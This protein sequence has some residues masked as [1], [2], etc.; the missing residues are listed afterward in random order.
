VP[1]EYV[2]LNLATRVADALALTSVLRHAFVLGN[3]ATDVNNSLGWPR[4]STHFWYRSDGENVSGAP[5]LLAR[6]PQLSA[7]SLTGPERAFVAGYLSHLISDEQEILTL[8]PY[9]AGLS[10]DGTAPDRRQVRLASL[11]AVDAAVEADDPRPMRRSVADLRAAMELQLRD[12]LLPFVA[13]TAVREWAA[14]TLAVA[15][16]PASWARI[17]PHRVGREPPSDVMQR[18]AMLQEALRLALPRAVIRDYLDRAT[19][20]SVDFLKAYLVG[21]PLPTPHGTAPLR[22]SRR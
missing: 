5:T 20:E 10:V 1:A 11:I 21:D 17:M 14:Q 2:H 18:V 15:D 16:L 12:D 19:R 4:E 9:I 22:S 7:R 13:M 3:V 8:P 6:H